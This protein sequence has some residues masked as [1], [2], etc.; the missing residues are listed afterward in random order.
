MVEARKASLLLANYIDITLG[1]I[2]RGDTADLARTRNDPFL[3]YH[4]WP[5]STTGTAS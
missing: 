2:D 4:L 1:A 5:C 3:L